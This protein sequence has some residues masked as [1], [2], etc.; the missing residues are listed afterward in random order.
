MKKAEILEQLEYVAGVRL[1]DVFY[2]DF[3]QSDVYAIYELSV[4]NAEK[5]YTEMIKQGVT[6]DEFEQAIKDDDLDI[7]VEDW[8]QDTIDFTKTAT[9]YG[10]SGRQAEYDLY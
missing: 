3:L 7:F 6:K 8:I 1:S 10:F 9:D 5:L 2:S 4:E